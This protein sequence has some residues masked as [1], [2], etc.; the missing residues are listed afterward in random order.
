MVAAGPLCR[1]ARVD[2][3]AFAVLAPAAGREA[4]AAL[5]A[6][7]LD[8]IADP[9]EIAGHRLALSCSIGIAVAPDDADSPAGLIANADLA[10]SRAKQR[11]RANCCFFESE[12]NRLRQEE[13][14]LGQDLAKAIANGELY[15]E[16]QPLFAAADLSLTG[17]EA[18]LRWQHPLHGQISPTVFV[19]LA[20]ASGTILAI[21]A[22]VLETA[23]TEAAGWNLPYRIAVN[24]SPVQLRQNELAQLVA[25][26]LR[27]TGLDPARLELEVT[28]GILINDPEH[29][30]A[31]LREMQQQGIRIALDDYG[32]GYSSLNYLRRFAFDKIKIDRSY[33][34]TLGHDPTAEM[35]AGSIMALGRG[36]DMTVTAEGVETEAQLALLRRQGCDHIQGFL[37][38]RPAPV[39]RLHHRIAAAPRAL[40]PAA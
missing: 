12:M 14:L 24:L 37:L 38:G 26:T 36:L 35:I 11:G 15:L 33:V 1:V 20:E 30:I 6:R 29:A 25:A 8:V 18:L 2:G 28:E 13:V 5:A 19:P 7:L 17:Y 9:F 39:E 27:R 32:T 23:C 31:M 21:G 34:A 40:A 4:A 16:Y 22:W 10:L 3:D